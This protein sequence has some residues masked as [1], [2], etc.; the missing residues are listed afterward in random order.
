M[1]QWSYVFRGDVCLTPARASELESPDAPAI[2]TRGPA[3][4][5]SRRELPVAALL[6]T[7]RPLPLMVAIVLGMIFSLVLLASDLESSGCGRDLGGGIW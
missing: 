3:A 1:D 4:T 5:T 2:A 6:A 7:R